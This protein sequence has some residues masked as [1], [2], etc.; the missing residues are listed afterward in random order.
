MVTC[1]VSLSHFVFHYIAPLMVAFTSPRT[2]LYHLHTAHVV[3]L[4]SLHFRINLLNYKSFLCSNTQR[5]FNQIHEN[6]KKHKREKAWRSL[7]LSF[8]FS[9]TAVRDESYHDTSINNDDMTVITISQRLLS[10]HCVSRLN[11]PFPREYLRSNVCCEWL[12]IKCWRQL[13]I[14]QILPFLMQRSFLFANFMALLQ[15]WTQFT[16]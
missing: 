12:E 2:F 14:S 8:P 16:E 4:N 7:K 1:V 13:D 15:I 6:E 10:L 5:S 3:M 11:L 9:F